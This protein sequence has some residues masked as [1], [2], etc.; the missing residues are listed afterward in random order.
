MPTPRG[1]EKR[2]MH[3]FGLARALKGI[4]Q[5]LTVL[6]IDPGGF[7]KPDPECAYGWRDKFSG[8]NT[9]GGA[10]GKGE[11]RDW[12]D[13]PFTWDIL[14]GGRNL[15]S[16][17]LH[18][19]SRPSGEAFQKLTATRLRL[20]AYTFIIIRKTTAA[21]KLALA[22]PRYMSF[23]KEQK[24]ANTRLFLKGRPFDEIARE[25]VDGEK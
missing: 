13:L 22:M 16:R 11:L 4:S 5:G 25:C 14:E 7:T 24:G 3:V 18:K 17:G 21:V 2:L 6:S 15:N 12:S 20:D 19:V 9:N 8:I 1:G 10:A 23:P